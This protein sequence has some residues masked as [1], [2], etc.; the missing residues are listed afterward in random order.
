MT[1]RQCFYRLVSCG[2]LENN[3]RSYN[4][5]KRL[6]T[7]ARKDG[8]IDF[9]WIVDRSRPTYSP[10]VFDNPQAYAETMKSI[11]RKDYWQTQPW[12]VEIWAEKDAICGAI[13]SITNDLG[14][15]VR[16]CRW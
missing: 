13:E 4:S 8:R 1:V 9:N 14:I 16:T 10:C 7:K 6:L 11:Y 15:I 5:I 3:K 2:A 12:H